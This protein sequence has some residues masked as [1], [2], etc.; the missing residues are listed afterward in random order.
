MDDTDVYWGEMKQYSNMK[1]IHVR[2]FK[3]PV[4]VSVCY[5]R[6]AQKLELAQKTAENR[7]K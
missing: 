7:A 2:M 6:A 4:C 3:A 1:S 5:V